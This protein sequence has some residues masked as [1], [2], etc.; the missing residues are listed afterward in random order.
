MLVG[1]LFELVVFDEQ[2][3]LGFM[4]LIGLKGFLILSLKQVFWYRSVVK[5]LYGSLGFG[6]LFRGLKF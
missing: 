1:L 2:A 3:F 4:F 6:L 5:C